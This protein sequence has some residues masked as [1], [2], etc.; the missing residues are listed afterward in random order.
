MYP[1]TIFEL[2]VVTSESVYYFNLNKYFV[3]NVSWTVWIVYC[4]AE[5]IWLKY[6]LGQSALGF[7]YVK[8]HS[9]SSIADVYKNDRRVVGSSP[10]MRNTFYF[11]FH[12]FITG[13]ILNSH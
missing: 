13:H 6:T 4:S 5:F 3:C 7:Q 9:T 1:C 8:R 2:T 12:F 11:L 10:D